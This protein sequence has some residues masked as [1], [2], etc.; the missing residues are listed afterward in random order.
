MFF[1]LFYNTFSKLAFICIFTSFTTGCASI[2]NGTNQ[3]VSV[4][5]TPV[6]GAS[7]TLENNKGKWYVNNTPGSVTVQRSYNDMHITCEKKGFKVVH[8][9]IPSN[10]KPMA[11]GNIVF[12]G[13]IGVGVDMADGAAYDYPTD[14]NMDMR[15]A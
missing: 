11:F 9:N 3:P 5:T 4:K 10:T 15:K 7:C 8:K 13:V 14:I 6:A 12:G 2:V 1:K